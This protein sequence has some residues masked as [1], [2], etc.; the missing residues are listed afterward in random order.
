MR[1]QNKLDR[2]HLAMSAANYIPMSYDIE[3]LNR[4]CLNKL[5]KHDKYIEEYGIDIEE[6]LNWKWESEEI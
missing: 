4:Y 3:E 5:E 1:V 2:Y 6:V